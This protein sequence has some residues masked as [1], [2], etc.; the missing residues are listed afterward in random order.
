MTSYEFGIRLSLLMNALRL[1][2]AGDELALP[3]E[4]TDWPLQVVLTYFE[5]ALDRLMFLL[6]DRQDFT[7]QD[8]TVS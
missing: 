3:N 4:S 1:Q 5:E 7:V 8:S 6:Q 2:L